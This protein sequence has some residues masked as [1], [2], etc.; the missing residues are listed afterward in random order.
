MLVWVKGEAMP[1][2]LIVKAGTLDDLSLNETKYKPKAEIYCRN[3][4]SWLPDVEG[5]AKF[6]GAMGAA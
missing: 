1:G 4:F 6:D 5:A 3:K 2:V